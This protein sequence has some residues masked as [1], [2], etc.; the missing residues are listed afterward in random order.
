M[1]AAVALPKLCTSASKTSDAGS[2]SGSSGEPQTVWLRYNWL[3]GVPVLTANA[4][5]S[6]PSASNRLLAP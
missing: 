2:H 3:S 1:S 6:T 4:K 5:I